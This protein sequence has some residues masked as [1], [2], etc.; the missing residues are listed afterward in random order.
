MYLH[1]IMEQL[2]FTQR[3]PSELYED[4]RTEIVMAENPVSRKASRPID[5]LRD[6]KG[7]LVGLGQVTLTPCQ[8]DKMVADALTKG[9]P[10]PAFE[11][12]KGSQ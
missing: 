11:R 1:A 4:S 10:V 12:H 7:E 6:Y 5:T 9:L 3:E 8:T 2:G